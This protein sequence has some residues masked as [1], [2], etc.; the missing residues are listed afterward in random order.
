MLHTHAHI[1]CTN[2]L[3]DILSWGCQR[4][5]F[6]CPLSFCLHLSV[7]RWLEVS[8]HW[9]SDSWARSKILLLENKIAVTFYT[10]AYSCLQCL[11]AILLRVN[12]LIDMLQVSL[13]MLLL[14]TDS[15]V[16][17]EAVLSKHWPQRELWVRHSMLVSVASVFPHAVML[18]TVDVTG[19]SRITSFDLGLFSILCIWKAMSL[20]VEVSHFTLLIQ[21]VQ[22]ERLA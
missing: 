2:T 12:L 17:K 19:N 11:K 18:C 1:Y 6:Y 14:E 3:H 22:S 10:E 4:A 21:F 5:E 20:S 13:H 16:A 8:F 9:R 7:C 15:H